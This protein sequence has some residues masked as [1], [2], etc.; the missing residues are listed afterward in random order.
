MSVEMGLLPADTI[1]THPPKKRKIGGNSARQIQVLNPKLALQNSGSTNYKEK[2]KHVVVDQEEELEDQGHDDD[3]DDNNQEDDD[4]DDDGSEDEMEPPTDPETTLEIGKSHLTT[5]HWDPMCPDGKKVGWR[6]RVADGDSD[7]KDGRIIRYDPCTHKHKIQFTKAFR[8]SDKVDSDNCAW[9]HLRMEDGIQIAAR[10][11][12]AHVKGYAWW[13]AMVME[14]DTNPAKEGYVHVEF[15]GSWE[16]ATLRESPECLRVFEHGKVDMVIQKNKKKRNANAIHLACQEELFIQTTRNKAARYYAQMAYQVQNRQGNNLVGKRVQVFRTDVNYPYGDTVSGKVKQYSVALKK[17]LVS[18]ELSNK[19]RKKYD[20]SWINLQSKE[21]KMRVLDKKNSNANPDELDIAPFVMGFHYSGE[22]HSDPEEGTDAHFDEVLRERCHGCVEYWKTDDDRLTCNT[23]KTDYHT[24]CADPPLSKEDIQKMKKNGEPWVCSKCVPCRGCYQKDVAFGSHRHPQPPTLSFRQGEN[25]DLCSMCV[26]MYEDGQ[27]C[28]NCAHSWNDE[29][30]QRVQRQI[31]WQQ[32]HRPKKRGRKRK[33][34]IADPT[35]APDFVS[36]T[37]PATTHTEE[38]L[39]F[40]AT[41]NPTWYYPETAQWGYT[42][43]DMLTCDSCKLWVHAGCADVNEIEYDQT[44]NGMHPIYSKEFLCRVCCRNRCKDLIRGLQAEDTMLLF[45]EPVTEKMAPNYR[46][47]IKEPMDLRTLELR[48]ETE[49]YNNYAWVRENLELMVLNALTFNRLHTAVWKEAKRYYQACLSNVFA[50]IGKAAPPQKYDAAIQ[51]NFAKAKEAIQMEEERVKEDKSTEKKDLVAGSTVATVKLPALREAPLDQASCLPFTEA[52]LRPVDAHYCCWMDSC[53]TCGSSGASDTMLFCVDCGEGFHS[54]CVNAPIHSMEASAVAG[55]RCPNCKICEI[56]GESCDELKMLFCEMCDR[57]FSLDLLDPPLQAAPPGLWIC[58]QCVDCRKCKNTS[59]PRGQSL[60]YWSRDPQ[61]C[62]RCGG[63]DGLV[64]QYKKSRKCPVCTG[65][66][67]DEDTDVAECSECETKVHKRCDPRASLY[68][69]KLETGTRSDERNLKYQCPQC[70]KKQGINK[71]TDK[72]HRGHLHAHAW[73]LISDG[74]LE[75]GENCSH[76]ELQEKLMDQ[77]DWKTRN[78]WRDE[79]RRVVLEGVRFMGLAKEQF[80]DP[81]LLMDRFW[82]ENIDLPTWMGQRATRFLQ[83]A[84]KLRLDTLGFSARRIENCVLVSKLAASWLE[85][86]CRTM[87]LT[88]KKNVKGYDRVMKLLTAPHDSG[89]VD[90]PFDSIRC[91]RNRNIIN[92][93][94]W[95]EKFEQLNDTSAA[96]AEPNG[97]IDG[98]TPSTDIVLATTMIVAPLCG[99]NGHLNE[100]DA[101]GAWS[102]PRECSLC[103]LCGDDDAGLPDD[104]EETP[105]DPS[106]PRVARVGRLLPLGD[107][108]WVHASCALWSSETWEAPTGGHINVM[109]KARSR[110]AHLRCCGCGRQGATVGCIKS[111]CSFN[112]HFPCASACGAVFTSQKEMYCEAHKDSTE[113]L[114]ERPS[115]EHM[116]TLI[117]AP[118]KANGPT[119]VEGN[120]CSRVGALVVHSFGEIERECDGF[121]SENYITPPGYVATRIFWSTVK[122]KTRTVYV[123]E[124]EKSLGEKPV[125]TITPGDNPSLKI[126]AHSVVQAYTMLMDRVRKAHIECFSHGDFF[127]KLPTARRSRKKVFGMSGPQVRPIFGPVDFPSHQLTRM[128]L[129]STVLWFRSESHSEN[130]GNDSWSR[131]CRSFTDREFP[132]LQILLPATRFRCYYRTPEKARRG[133]R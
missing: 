70:C 17:W 55:W 23:C 88:T 15:F 45:A 74:T 132:Q 82:H 75:P 50:S 92:K 98:K 118:E 76:L 14:S 128:L 94:E 9:L 20:A 60:K 28:P 63:C 114:T 127:S 12:W 99:W 27:Y 89:S 123:L 117:V 25:L 93:D 31:R 83:I 2:E 80:G 48:A 96:P 29:Q 54:F 24:T 56:S 59:E 124:V 113:D 133:R 19:S 6:I 69:T 44:S 100:T 53:F 110:G 81:R 43:V 97:S 121:H 21:H 68:L 120:L 41:V 112:Y 61:L 66:W 13:P 10:I 37:A 108:F 67:R 101:A 106:Q 71:N 85:I 103:H 58:G 129:S 78:L 125:F 38:P 130:F 64:D 46:D 35:S 102:D 16:V 3:D 86:A 62:Y 34:E 115:T 5:V 111:N 47:V 7:W 73:K 77:I 40:G 95:L 57:G 26:S 39:L 32:A 8:S 49:E 4:D 90:L 84:K 42:E 91:E 79:Y 131:G 22:R 65:V 1:I 119:E 51:A 30:F 52:K 18:Y 104:P 72:V 107:G 116:K 122:P 87:G 126:R 11:V 105:S 36:F 33:S 109:E